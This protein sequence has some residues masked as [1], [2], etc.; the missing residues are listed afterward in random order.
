MC[1]KSYKEG[2]TKGLG[3]LDLAHRPYVAHPC[4][5]GSLTNVIMKWCKVFVRIEYI[6]YNFIKNCQKLFR[7]ASSPISLKLFLLCK[8]YPAGAL[9]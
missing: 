1:K 2:L 8:F 4:P 6:F 3:G 7:F 5:R 9:N